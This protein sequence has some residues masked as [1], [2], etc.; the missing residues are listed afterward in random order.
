VERLAQKE[1]FV[2]GLIRQ[3]GQ[4]FFHPFAVE[5]KEKGGNNNLPGGTGLELKYVETR[6]GKEGLI[7][8]IAKE[9]KASMPV[10][11]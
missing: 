11:S 5:E 8:C 10:C 6:G 9:E 1:K 7:N 4:S 2:G 3:A